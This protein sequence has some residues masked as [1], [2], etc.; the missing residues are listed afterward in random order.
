MVLGS[1]FFWKPMIS[2]ISRYAALLNTY[3]KVI[4]WYDQAYPAQDSG[5]DTGIYI[6]RPS[7]QLR[8]MIPGWTK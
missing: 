2:V 3:A 4:T 6:Y 1:F 8:R 7:R 5:F